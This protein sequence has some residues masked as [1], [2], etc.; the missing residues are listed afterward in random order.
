MMFVASYG[1]LIFLV[2]SLLT[3]SSK[4]TRA[5]VYIPTC[6][7]IHSIVIISRCEVQRWGYSSGRRLLPVGRS[8]GNIFL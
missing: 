8:S 7:V 1:D 5:Y 3:L 6:S 4:L 2:F